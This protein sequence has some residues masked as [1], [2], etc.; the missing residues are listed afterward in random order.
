MGEHV[1]E[2]AA[3]TQEVI[4]ALGGR[5]DAVPIVRATEGGVT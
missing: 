4:A 3:F 5:A 2:R 1:I